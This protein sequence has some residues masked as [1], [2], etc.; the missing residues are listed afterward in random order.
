MKSFRLA[1]LAFFF[2]TGLINA[3]AYY[4]SLNNF[5]L[6]EESESV[7]NKDTE[8]FRLGLRNN[9]KKL[10]YGDLQTSNNGSNDNYA[11]FYSLKIVP[12]FIFETDFFDTEIK[13]KYN[14]PAEG[15]YPSFPLIYNEYLIKEEDNKMGKGD[16]TLNKGTVSLQFSEKLMH[17][18]AKELKNEFLLERINYE[19][20]NN[21]FEIN[22]LGQFK[23]DLKIKK[24]KITKE[25]DLSI[26]IIVEKG[27]FSMYLLS[28]K[29]EI[30]IITKKGNAA[31]F[32]K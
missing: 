4:P 31:D 11:A 15:K 20:K 28:D 17:S 19:F 32:K 29:K 18:L 27:T 16:M 2:T 22:L 24:T 30:E 23:N 3:Q 25:T 10:F 26:K 21:R 5:F 1:F 6:Y 14:V 7:F 12:R 8:F 13:L 9:F